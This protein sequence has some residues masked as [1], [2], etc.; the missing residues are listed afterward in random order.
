MAYYVHYILLTPSNKKYSS[1]QIFQAS[2]PKGIQVLTELS[3]ENVSNP[4]ES[5]SIA[6]NL[7]EQNFKYEYVEGMRIVIEHITR[8]WRAAGSFLVNL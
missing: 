7:Q 6:V 8:R 1:F 4:I 2:K 3:D 5:L